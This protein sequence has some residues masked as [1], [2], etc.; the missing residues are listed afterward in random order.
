MGAIL[1]TADLACSSRATGAATSQQV[2]CET[3]MSVERLL[4]RI[5]AEPFGLVLLDLNTP[6][7]DCRT[8]VPQLRAASPDGTTIIAF[9]PHVHEAK[10]AQARSAGCD[11]VMARGQF[12]GQ[13]AEIMA[14]AKK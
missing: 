11:G 14:R 8:F 2:P 9:G 6:G 13:L 7:L 12:Y 5:S 1:L 10:L 4:E 3:A